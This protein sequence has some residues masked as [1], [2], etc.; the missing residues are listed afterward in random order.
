[1]VDPALR[2]S[3]KTSGSN[4]LTNSSLQVNSGFVNVYLILTDKVF[5]A[6]AASP[7]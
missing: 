2:L 4:L 5:L 7:G 3:L 1:V 6:A